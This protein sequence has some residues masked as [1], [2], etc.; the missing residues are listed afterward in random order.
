MLAG[1]VI[2]VL[3][4]GIYFHDIWNAWFDGPGFAGWWKRAPA[5]AFFYVNL[6][7]MLAACVL[8]PRLAQRHIRRTATLRSAVLAAA[9]LAVLLYRHGAHLSIGLA[10]DHFFNPVTR[11]DLATPSAAI[12]SI[13]R[14]NDAPFRVAGLG[15]TLFPGF[16]A[17]YGLENIN[18]PDAIMNRHYHEFAEAA[19]L[20]NGG[21]WY[22]PID[23]AGVATRRPILDFLGVRY[24]LSSA[25]ELDPAAGFAKS[26]SFDLEVYRSK[27]AWPRAFF[28]DR[29]EHYATTA[30]FV[31]MIRAHG[32][33]PF[34]ATQTGDSGVPNLPD[35]AAGKADHVIAAHDYRLT[36]NTTA[37]TISAPA[38][39]AIVLHETW[40]PDDFHVTINGKPAPYFRVNHAFKGVTVPAAGTYRIVV[41]YWPK[42]FTLSL[43]MAAAGVAGFVALL[44]WIG[45]LDRSSSAAVT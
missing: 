16:N 13:N 37:F 2:L 24:L 35:A 43:L 15:Y 26:G 23:V 40:L 25:T 9:L 7:L 20:T 21:D 11:V 42:N 10:D 14:D 27:T 1:V 29:L 12:D 31:S 28:T 34:A 32:D 5:H 19:G 8:L 18:G 30:S 3:L 44:G 41:K 36:A 33:S 6:A 38:A 22:F 39:G 45:R 17:V 4:L